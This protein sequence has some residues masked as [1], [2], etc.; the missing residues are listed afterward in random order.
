RLAS[1][2]SLSVIERASKAGALRIA[3]ISVWEIG[4]LEAKGRISFPITCSDWVNQTLSAPGISLVPLLPEIAIESSR[5]PGV[6]HGDP[7]DR[8]LVASARN[9]GASL[10]TDDSKIKEYG[11]DG[12]VRIISV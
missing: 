8:I 1:S 10:V 5:L 2:K 6:F 4:M 9:L 12:H 3:A 7:A 11:K